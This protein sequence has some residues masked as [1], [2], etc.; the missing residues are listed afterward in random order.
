MKRALSISQANSLYLITLALIITL[1]SAVQLLN[2]SWGLVATELFLILLPAVLFLRIKGIPLREGLRLRPVGLRT[3]VVCTLIG[4]S[5]WFLASYIDAL[6]MQLSGMAP[7]SISSDMLPSGLLESLVYF[8]AL[9][10]FAPI[11]EEALFR[12][13]IQG[14][15]ERH[16]S[17]RFA[18]IMASLMFAFYHLRV[19]GLPALLP[20]AFTLGY[21]GWRTQSLLAVI[22]VH[23][24]NN[25]VSA[26][27]SLLALNLPDFNFSI[28]NPITAGVG[29]VATLGLLYLFN[30]LVPAP[31][32]AEEALATTPAPVTAPGEAAAE[33]AAAQPGWLRNYWALVVAGLLFAVVG[34]LTLAVTLNPKLSAGR[35]VI[36]GEPAEYRYV[37][38]NRLD[39]EVG[40]AVC[41]ITPG[42]ETTRLDCS[43]SV[44]G[45]AIQIGQSFFSEGTHTLDW[46]AAWDAR[47]LALVD[48]DLQR[49]EADG[50]IS[51]T[52]ALE[53]GQLGLSAPGG[54][55][56]TQEMG[57]DILLGHEW[58]WRM[59]NLDDSA[60]ATSLVQFGYLLTWD[61]SEQRSRPQVREE[62]LRLVALDPVQV[63]AGRFDA[64]KVLIGDDKAAWYTS[65]SQ[66]KL[67][68]Y[69][70]GMSIYS[71]VE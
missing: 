21:V 35:G 62:M 4:V 71:L 16:R 50:E 49:T 19:T 29:L 36:F 58:A 20:I 27:Y 9:A 13:A 24:G 11:C 7:V 26:S 8:S 38:T 61:E 43:R 42:A 48:F 15:Y 51:L 1:G 52:A 67:L 32:A 46:S 41:T 23:F 17:P 39:A 60:G 6:I 47:T 37:I 57:P 25:A 2:L 5:M 12:G 56:E 31:A 68:R 59:V 44:E 66:P 55:A 34:G 28:T 69:D 18:I 30:R 40:Q 65:G 64:W 63:P 3:A 53:A 22:L 54:L 45:Y 10:I 33:P 14:A 70:D